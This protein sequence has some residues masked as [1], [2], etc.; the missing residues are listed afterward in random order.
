VYD[1]L[2]P[3][4]QL[5]AGVPTAN[6]LV[7]R[8]LDEYLQS[9][10]SSGTVDFLSDALGSVIA[11]AGQN[12]SL[13]N[14]YTYDP[15]GNS[16]VTGNSPNAFQYTGRENDNDGW[17][18]LRARY[19]SPAFQR[20]ASEDPIGF[21]GGPNVYSYARNN[22][23]SYLDPNGRDPVIG[24]TV[25]VILGGLT[26]AAAAAMQGGSNTEI[27]EAAAEGAIVGLVG[28][29]ADPAMGLGV[30]A[31]Y[32]GVIGGVANIAGQET[33]II[34]SSDPC[35]QFS[36][37]GLVGAVWTG[38]VSVASNAAIPLLQASLEVGEWA[39]TA[40]ATGEG[41]AL[42]SFSGP[43]IGQGVEWVQSQM[44]STLTPPKCGCH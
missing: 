11:L 25:G 44:P 31:V 10:T 14:T 20:F 4:Q 18:F 39:A 30:L 32:G 35:K 2:N 42:G 6:F 23:I 41:S 9:T 1:N 21:G 17:Y 43:L 29:F 19:Y 28:G 5:S 3:V 27:I 16:T 24:A 15:F 36:V 38:A 40:L 12:G 8:G 37:G 33:V 22:P 26:G 13:L 34:N 7:G